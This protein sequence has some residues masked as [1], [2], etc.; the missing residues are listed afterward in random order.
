MHAGHGEGGGFPMQVPL[1]PAPVAF[2]TLMLGLMIG[3]MIG[4]R[5]AAMMH[6]M[7]GQGMCGGQGMGGMG[8][9]HMGMGGWSDEAGWDS[10]AAKKKMMCGTSHHH[11]GDGTPPC[12][13]AAGEQ[14]M[15]SPDE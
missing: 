11:H 4:R 3:M 2:M 6:G 8:M 15:D 10:W 13:C 12:D 7:G 9:G 5:K 1:I 14:A